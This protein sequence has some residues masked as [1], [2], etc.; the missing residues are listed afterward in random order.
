MLVLKA[1]IERSSYRINVTF[2][3]FYDYRLLLII[4]GTNRITCLNGA[5][6]QPGCCSVPL[7]FTITKDAST[8]IPTHEPNVQ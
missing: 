8:Y 6:I 4:T 2:A 5:R 7:V 1:I 3:N